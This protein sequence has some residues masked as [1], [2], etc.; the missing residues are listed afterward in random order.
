MAATGIADELS[1]MYVGARAIVLSL[2][3]PLSSPRSRQYVGV[4]VDYSAAEPEGVCLPLE[5]LITGP[6]T[7]SFRRRIFRR[8]LPTQFDFLPIEG[9]KHQLLLREVTHNR[10]VG[11]LTVDVIGD[12]LEP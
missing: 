10:Y 9:G 5:L 1:P 6:S 12:T 7:G 8:V 3:D 2:L 11:A 4:A